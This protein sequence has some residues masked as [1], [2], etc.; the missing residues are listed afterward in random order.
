MSTGYDFFA[1]APVTRPA[2]APVATVVT[3]QPGWY[4]DPHLP[5]QLRWFDGRQWTAHVAALPVPQR[6]RS[7]EALL[8]V[9]RSGL[10]IAAGYAGLFAI[11]LVFAPVA[12]VLGVLA[13]RDLATKPTVGGRGRAWFGV[14]AGILG[15]LGLVAAVLH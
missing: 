13:L 5:Q 1:T 11:L 6:D 10:A 3:P 12:L 15:T 4:A 9:N 8:P 7:M 14:V 2:T